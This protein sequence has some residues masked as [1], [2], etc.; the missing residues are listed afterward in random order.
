MS[1]FLLELRDVTKTYPGVT[2][3]DGVSWVQTLVKELQIPG[4]DRW[5]VRREHF[6]DV[7]AKASRASSMKANP[8]LLTDGELMEIVNH[9]L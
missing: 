4:L 9:S 3:L 5:G 1:E 8:V 2:A 6:A 7:V